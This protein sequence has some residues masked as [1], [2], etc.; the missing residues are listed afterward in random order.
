M[1]IRTYIEENYKELLEIASKFTTDNVDLLHH[2]YLKTIDKEAKEP[3]YYILTTFWREAKTMRAGNFKDKYQYR[4]YETNDPISDDSIDAELIAKDRLDFHLNSFD[5]FDKGI[6]KLWAD[7]WD[8]SRFSR[9]S[10]IPYRTV[11]CSV[12]KVVTHLKNVL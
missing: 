4:T 6:Y 8:M 7:G 2:V 10:G 5:E 12:S 1:K 9:E 11:R 3:K